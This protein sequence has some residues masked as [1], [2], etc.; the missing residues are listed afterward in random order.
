MSVSATKVEALLSV[1]ATFIQESSVRQFHFVNI[2]IHHEV[3]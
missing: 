1:F 3:S 2:Q